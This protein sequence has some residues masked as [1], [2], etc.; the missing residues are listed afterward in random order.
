MD[1]QLFH[2]LEIDELKG[3]TILLDIDGTLVPDGGV[4]LARETRVQVEKLKMENVVYL[5][6]NKPV[7]DRNRAL[8]RDIDV[9]YLDTA[10]RKPSKAILKHIPDSYDPQTL[11][12]IG[13]K[14]ITDGLFARNIKAEFIKVQRMTREHESMVLRLVYFVDDCIYR[15][16]RL[17]WN[18]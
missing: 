9:V 12:V 10:I 16:A 18:I 8:S 1:Q 2:N 7:P 4:E 13:D 3:K 17:V 15:I 14:F 6:S 5:C 11:L